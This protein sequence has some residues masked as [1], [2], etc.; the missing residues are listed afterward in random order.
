MTDKPQTIEE[1]C[2]NNI[3]AVIS[4]LEQQKAN[5][6]TQIQTINDTLDIYYYLKLLV[7]KNP[8]GEKER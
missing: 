4:S 2:L 6:Q 1:L 5:A 8:S 7:N 3:D